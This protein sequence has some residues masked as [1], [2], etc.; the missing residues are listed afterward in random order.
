MVLDISLIRVHPE[1][2]LKSQNDRFKDAVLL[3][4]DLSDEIIELKNDLYE[5][6]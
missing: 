1:V 2:V 4:S 3:K 6:N 5:M